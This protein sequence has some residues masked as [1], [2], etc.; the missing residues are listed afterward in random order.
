M[1]SAHWAEP[2]VTVNSVIDVSPPQLPS[3]AHC[4]STPGAPQGTPFPCA[5]LPAHSG[6]PGAPA[7]S[8]GMHSGT[9]EGLEVLGGMSKGIWSQNFNI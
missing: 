3:P 1:H 5:S 2:S 4:R 7:V 6:P 9:I 8:S